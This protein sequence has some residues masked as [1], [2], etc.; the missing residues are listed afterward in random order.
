MGAFNRV[1]VTG[2]DYIEVAVAVDAVLR[3]LRQ[4]AQVKRE[5]AKALDRFLHPLT[6]GPTAEGWKLGRDVFASEI[7]SVVHTV[8][9]V[10]YLNSLQL[11]PSQAQH[12]IDFT[13]PFVCPFDLPENTLIVSRDGRKSALLGESVTAGSELRSLTTKGFKVGDRIVQELNAGCLQPAT[14]DHCGHTGSRERHADYW[15]SILGI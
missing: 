11:I 2:P 3:D 6:G 8:P 7:A 5:I 13:S 4:A 14:Y 12:R 1:H 9:G 15:H 10:D